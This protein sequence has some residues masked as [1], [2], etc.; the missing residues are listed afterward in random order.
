MYSRESNSKLFVPKHTELKGYKENSH[1]LS[2][3][4]RK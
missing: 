3:P 4:V 1:Q 2:K